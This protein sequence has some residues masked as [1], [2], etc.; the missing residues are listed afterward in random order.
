MKLRILGCNGAELPGHNSS[1]Y[2]IDETLLVDAGA[3]CSVLTA[4]EQEAIRQILVTHTHMDHVKGIPLLA[5]NRCIGRTALPFEVVGTRES[6][7]ALRDHLFN[8]ILW[9]DFTRLPDPEH[10]VVRYREI[11][12]EEEFCI[13]G[14]R[15]I[16]CPVNHTVPTVGYRISSG[17]S[18]LLFSGDTGPT[19]RLWELAEGVDALVVEVSFPNEQEDMAVVSRHLTARQLGIELAKVR[20]L[21]GR[22]LISHLKPQFHDVIS[23]EVAALGLPGVELLRDGTEFDF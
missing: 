1:A 18:T 5:D 19:E 17:G 15:V 6:I 9:P 21:P 16:A 13:D 23:A 3:V 2:L 14:Y 11:V 10:P 22:I 20:R 7:G 12:P 8:D 4:R